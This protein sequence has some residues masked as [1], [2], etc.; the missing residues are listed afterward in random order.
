MARPP[1]LLLSESNAPTIKSIGKK[2]P[3]GFLLNAPSNQIFPK[4]PFDCSHFSTTYKS[5]FCHDDGSDESVS[6]LIGARS[7]CGKRDSS[8][9]R[10][11]MDR[12]IFSC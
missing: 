9:S 10:R 12:F 7:I 5:S 8:Y 6:G 2:E 1:S 3:S 11:D 4:A